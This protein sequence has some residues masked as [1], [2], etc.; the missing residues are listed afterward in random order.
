[1]G[2]TAAG[3]QASW[4]GTLRLP[5]L[6]QLEPRILLSG[7]DELPAAISPSPEAYQSIVLSADGQGDYNDGLLASG[8]DVSYWV[9]RPD[10]GGE[11]TLQTA[12]SVDTV[13]GLYDAGGSRLAADDDS[14]E[15]SNAR[16]ST[17]LQAATVYWVVLTGKGASSGQFGLAA[18]GPAQGES[19]TNLKAFPPSFAPVAIGRIDPVHDV[20]YW[21]LPVPEGGVSV[22]VTLQPNS[23]DAAFNGVLRLED[24]DGGTL[25]EMN[26]NGPGENEVIA[27]MPV[28]S[29]VTYF[30]VVSAASGTSGEYQLNIS[31][32]VRCWVTDSSIQVDPNEVLSGETVAGEGTLLGAGYGTVEYRWVAAQ[33]DGSTW[34]SEIL[35]THLSEGS[36]DV[37]QFTALPTSQA[38]GYEVYLRIEAPDGPEDLTDGA[39]IYSVDY[40][41]VSFSG[42]ASYLEA[43]GESPVYRPASNCEAALLD[44]AGGVVETTRTGADGSFA[45]S[46][47]TALAGLDFHVRLA[48]RSGVAEVRDETGQAYVFL[49]QP[50]TVLAGGTYSF[51]VQIDADGGAGAWHILD[52]VSA[53]RDFLVGGGHVLDSDIDGVVVDWHGGVAE[54]GYSQGVMQIAPGLELADAVVLD[55]FGQYVAAR[56]GFAQAS[57]GGEHYLDQR[58]SLV[59]PELSAFQSEAFSFAQGWAHLFASAVLAS[60]YGSGSLQLPAELVSTAPAGQFVQADPESG[61]ILAEDGSQLAVYQNVL[62]LGSELAVWGVLWDLLDA[63]AD[64]AD[65]DDAVWADSTIGNPPGKPAGWA[66]D[67]VS[68]A[69][70]FSTLWAVLV[71]AKPGTLAGFWA[72]W[73]DPEAAPVSW[74]AR[75]ATLEEAYRLFQSREM[76]LSFADGDPPVAELLISADAVLG[77]AELNS[78]GYLD[79]RFADVGGS[80]LDTLS[81]LDAE[82]EFGL[83]G[84]A[85]GGVVVNGSPT[86]ISGSES[87]YR[88]SFTGTFSFGQ[89]TVSFAPGGVNDQVG[90][91]SLAGESAFTVL[92]PEPVVEYT[93]EVTDLYGSP[94]TLVVAGQEIHLAVYADDLRSA[95]PLGGVYAGYV[96]LEYDFDLIDLDG[97][98]IE[99]GLGFADAS[100]GTIL[101]G[102]GLID[103]AGGAGADPASPAGADRQLLFSVVGTVATVA[104]GANIHLSIN[105]AEGA[106]HETRLYGLE[107]AVPAGAITYG[108][109]DVEAGIGYRNPNLPED[110]NDNGTVEALDALIL[111]NKLNAEGSHRLEPASDPLP[112]PSSGA[113]WDVNGDDWLSPLDALQVINAINIVTAPPPEE[114]GGALPAPTLQ[115]RYDI[116]ATDLAGSPIS[117]VQVGKTF[118]LLGTVQDLRPTADGVFAAYVDVAY[119]LA[120]VEAAGLL[121]HGDDYSNGASGVIGAGLLD[122]VGGFSGLS[123]LGQTPRRV[124]SIEMLAT[125]A[126]EVIFLADPADLLPAHY[127]LLFGRNDA[128]G[129][130][131]INFA[132]VTLTITQPPGTLGLSVSPAAF[133]ESAGQAASLGTV[134]RSGPLDAALE[135]SLSSSDQTEALAPAGV[136][137]PAGQASATFSITAVDDAVVDGNRIVTLTASA[138]GFVS[139]LAQVSV[140]DNDVA[141]PELPDLVLSAVSY[142]GDVLNPGDSLSFGWAEANSD[143]GQSGAFTVQFRLSRDAI[144]GNA[145]DVVLG[146][147]ENPDG[148]EAGQTRSA[149][150][151]ATVPASVTPGSYRLIAMIDSL[152]G[153]AETNEQNNRWL[154]GQADVVIIGDDHGDAG[155]WSAAAR[156]VFDP[157]TRL[158]VVSGLIEH[159]AD[160][161]LLAFTAEKNLPA[162]VAVTAGAS[163]E[164]RVDLFE[165]GGAQLAVNQYASGDVSWAWVDLVAGETYYVLISPQAGSTGAYTVEIDQGPPAS[166]LLGKK[167]GLP[168][169]C[170]FVDA[171]GD[172]VRI[173]YAGKGVAGI[174]LEGGASNNADIAAVEIVGSDRRGALMVLTR[175][176][177]SATTLGDV[178]VEGSLG[179]IIAKTATLDGDIDVAGALAMLTLG[180]VAPGHQIILNSGGGPVDPRQSARLTFGRVADLALNTGTMGIRSL[181]AAEWL[182]TGGPLE[183]FEAAWISSLQIRGRRGN[184]RRGVAGLAGDFQADLILSG[185]G[186][187]PR[188]R[189]LGNVRIAGKAVGAWSVTGDVGTVRVGDTD[190]NWVFQA[191]GQVGR[192]QSLGTMGG[193]IIGG[194]FRQINARGALTGRIQAT[195]Q[196]RGVSIGML[197]AGDVG[198]AVVI[199]RGGIKMVRAARWADGEI[200]AD[201]LGNLMITGDRR[202]GVVGDFGADVKLLGSQ[203]P[204]GRA[205]AN[206]KIAGDLT[207]ETWEMKGDL[208]AVRVLGAARNATIRCT[209]EMFGLTLGAAYGSSFLAGIDGG[210]NPHPQQA[211]D[212]SSS[213]SRIRSIRVV[214]LRLAKGAPRPSFYISQT[215]FAAASIGTVSLVNGELGTCG[216][217]ALAGSDGM[218]IRRITH[219]DMADGARW[220]WPE[221]NGVVSA[222]PDGVIHIIG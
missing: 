154:A 37:R 155:Q 34:T 54:T 131:E 216:I 142:S 10:V 186:S 116:E 26:V 205:L 221:R 207:S 203:A 52:A 153:V 149:A 119:D 110:V 222:W 138:G 31:Y 94:V 217:H 159:S 213:G 75:A 188:G 67:P 174:F 126:G 162:V 156:V 158:G 193:S 166:F 129:E 28:D 147:F 91:E 208:G 165:N 25:A 215:H 169:R 69:E 33:P 76:G 29:G 196:N 206:A 96:D 8:D 134:T 74:E 144:W 104:A 220:T 66:T 70:G 14:G 80:G 123:L 71:T 201:W 132:S 161:D 171:D 63:N 92:P 197:R 163:L 164:L 95:G 167:A 40:P 55:V 50:E 3:M 45:F 130:S 27:A 198:E 39:V 185:Q 57:P 190:E 219:V 109:A 59:R 177:G 90:N 157:S 120:L 135:I 103:E 194:T 22:S 38:G 82:E 5:G 209:G 65:P 17:A 61:T 79:I 9:I 182:N 30:L 16:I 93:V 60:Q 48:A 199:A 89:V 148:L 58:V 128:V 141:A 85:A 7:I 125:Q 124:F 51:D 64:E 122:E 87:D 42:V 84:A 210:V 151:A 101:Q 218:A 181:V 113:Y 112:I 97:A 179:R 106:G 18:A 86:L 191:T 12:G 114:A 133:S 36:A 32:E 23:P 88:Y 150:G 118:R 21:R 176:R 6:E 175:G 49:S 53:G 46:P 98:T 24:A 200:T 77:Q 178:T 137:I 19:A 145:D 15:G 121:V 146:A 214:G 152:Q 172:T 1:M 140:T 168:S 173:T 136:T 187:P 43:G 41:T 211:A 73:T 72:G 183:A 115:V 83:V 20:D 100:A 107:Q 189:A 204:R 170:S 143:D 2:K 195:G 127:T 13:M 180:D 35:S 99:Y 111:I 160:T 4:D 47:M 102:D 68:M 108:A 105:P 44:G 117:S 184:A 78:Q 81:I 192:L 62:G 212:F 139:A 11:F 56:M 202:S